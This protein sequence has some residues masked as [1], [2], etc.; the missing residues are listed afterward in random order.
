MQ[1][2][3]RAEVWIAKAAEFA[4]PM[5]TR[6]REQAH[7]ICPEAEEVIKW[8]MPALVYRGTNLCGLAGF[9]GHVGLFL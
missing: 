6:L 1:T 3:A 9:K 8:G 4:R 5:P 7:A 2:D